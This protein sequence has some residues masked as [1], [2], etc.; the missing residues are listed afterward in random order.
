MDLSLVTLNNLILTSSLLKSIT[1]ESGEMVDR[2]IGSTDNLGQAPGVV[3]TVFQR[4]RDNS[5]NQV[6]FFDMSNLFYGKKIKPGSIRLHDPGLTGSVDPKESFSDSTT[7]IIPMTIRDNGNGNLYRADALTPH[8]TWSSIGNV[9]YDEGIFIIKTP[10][11]PL[12]GKD[13]HIIDFKGEHDVHVMK[14]MVHSPA[15]KINSSSNVAYQ[16]V[17]GSTQMNSLDSKF[18]YITG[19][20]F[21]DENFNI[22]AKTAFA[23]PVVKNEVDE[24]LFKTKIDF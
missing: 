9:F 12:F 20:N 1:A 7:G 23:Q 19:I 24:Y 14:V 15:G 11:I 16:N 3:L 13:K 22:I 21:H 17:S 2:I 6:V 18:V 8:A 5:S 4:T 10:N